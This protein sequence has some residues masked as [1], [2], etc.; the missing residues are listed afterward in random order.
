M[1][2]HIRDNLRYV[3]GLDGTTVLSDSLEL[4]T[5][6]HFLIAVC[7]TTQRDAMTPAAGWMIYN[8]T[9]ARAEIYNGST[10]ITAGATSA[11]STYAGDN[12]DNKQIAVG[13][14]CKLVIIM[15]IAGYS[16][17][18]TLISTTATRNMIHQQT[19]GSEHIYTAGTNLHATDGFVISK[20][21]DNANNTGL[22]YSYV[23]IG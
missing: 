12:A 11:V 10:W 15:D 5:N 9:T 1:N 18:W 22:N 16:R 19:A 4:P 21:S 17:Q 6:E 20:T 23:A 7:T 2:A 13:F 3:K 14:T 8:S